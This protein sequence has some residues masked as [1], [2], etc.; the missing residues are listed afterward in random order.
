MESK[1][2]GTRA[3]LTI[4][5][6]SK[7][8]LIN[9]RDV[10]IAERYPELMKLKFDLPFDVLLDGEICYF[11]KGIS[12]FTKLMSREH[13]TDKFKINL[14]SKQMPVTFVAFDVLY[15]GDFNKDTTKLKLI[16]R[17][18][19]L[20]SL[21]MYENPNFKIIPYLNDLN[22]AKEMFKDEEGIILKDK[23]SVYEF[24]TR[25]DKWLKFKKRVEKII[26]FTDYE[27]NADGSV[28]LT[29]GFHRVKCNDLNA[30]QIFEGNK[31]V[32]C[33][34]EGLEFTETGHI[35]MPVIKR[36]L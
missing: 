18:I 14:L 22:K 5:R 16:E 13:L 26:R 2:D 19:L 34:V 4:K 17:K 20:D 28:T 8:V 12:N 23:N 10:N 25:S 21:K 7:N 24:N 6:D 3:F 30:I 36:L 33:E 35:R 32:D 9:R 27:N 15:F 11:E 1:L 29:D 31:F